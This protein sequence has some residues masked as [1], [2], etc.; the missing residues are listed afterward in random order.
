[1]EKAKY[2]F[3]TYQG[4]RKSDGAPFY[5]VNLLYYNTRFNQYQ[6]RGLYVDEDV[7]KR[8]NGLGLAFGTAVATVSDLD[9]GLVDIKPDATFN[10]LN[11]NQLARH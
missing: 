8:V 6:F 1:M 9:G 4:K 2:Y 3:G 7:Y 11:L 5:C 10:S